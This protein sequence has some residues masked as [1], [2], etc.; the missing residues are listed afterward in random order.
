MT[1]K[2]RFLKAINR[3]VPDRLPVTTHHVMESYL[4]RYEDG[5]PYPEF[6][7]K[8]GLDPIVW[9]QEHQARDDQRKV[10]LRTGDYAM[11]TD[12]WDI[13]SRVVARE[14]YL[15]EEYEIR[16]AGGILTMELQRGEHTDWISQHL[17]KKKK[18]IDLVA[19][20]APLYDADVSRINGIAAGMGEA[21][22][23]R[24]TVPCFE[25]YGQPGCWQ[26]LA[27]LY[28]I[29]RLIYE[30]FD[31][32]QWVHTALMILCE[33]KKHYMHTLTGAKLDIIELGG[34]DASTTVISPAIF[35]EFVAPYDA[36]IIEEAHKAGQKIVYHTCGGMMPILEDIVAMAPDAV[37]T[38]TPPRMGGDADLRVA[39]QRIG[40]K[41]CLIGGFDQGTYFWEST[42]EET[43]AAVRR[44]FEEAGEGGGFILS[45]SDHFFDAKEELLRAF[46]EEAHSCIYEGGG[47]S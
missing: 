20:Y 46:A 28:G 12:S 38:L 5:I 10:Q 25:I 35:N 45:P 13:S 22:L 4:N 14:P 19:D 27:C 30:T 39:K 37:E 23:V 32:P 17:L 29:E 18:D 11:V 15:T 26:D 7:R 1:A 24:G 41:V 3:E 36:Q 2:E 21:G 43:R 40:D 47:E 34:G 6:F 44:A 9:V 8:Y 31:D 16:T 42:P 33:R